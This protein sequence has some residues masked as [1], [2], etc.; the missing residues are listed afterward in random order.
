MTSLII[1]VNWE[2]FLGILGTLIALAYY[3]NGRFTKLE[4]SVEWLKDAMRE[5]K[6]TS[7]KA[8]S[9]SSPATRSTRP[10]RPHVSRHSDSRSG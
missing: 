4:T 9:A 2:Y 3:A 8:V 10:G 7:A 1:N 6:I 5:L